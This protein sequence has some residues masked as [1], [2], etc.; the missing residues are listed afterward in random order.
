MVVDAAPGYG[1]FQ[2]ADFHHAVGDL[3]RRQVGPRHGV[4]A[5]A[6]MRGD[7]RGGGVQ[8]RQAAL[9]A[10]QVRYQGEQFRAREYR[11]ARYAKPPHLDAAGVACRWLGLIL[12]LDIER[13]TGTRWFEVG[14]PLLFTQD[15][16]RIRDD[17]L[18]TCRLPINQ[19]CGEGE[20]DKHMLYRSGH[21]S[22]PVLAAGTTTAARASRPQGCQV[23][24]G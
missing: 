3:L 11:V 8:F 17:R 24:R 19:R 22:L 2:N 15:L 6:V 10:G 13:W 20:P 12:V 1:S 9:G 21:S 14:R 18:C 7:A 4:A 5:F 23:R 16:A